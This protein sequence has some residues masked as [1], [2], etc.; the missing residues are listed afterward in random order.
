MSTESEQEF[1]RL[2]NLDSGSE[3]CDRETAQRWWN[4]ALDWSRPLVVKKTKFL[5][6]QITD[7]TVIIGKLKTGQRQPERESVDGFSLPKWL[8]REAW[9]GFE[10]MRKKIRRPLTDRAR[11]LTISKLTDLKNGGENAVACLD[12][13]TQRGWQGVFAMSQNGSK[14]VRKLGADW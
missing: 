12:Q 11:R 13:S 6:S 8:P 5:T 4:R 7:L 2:W 10:E 14:Q 9:D 3:S 1:V